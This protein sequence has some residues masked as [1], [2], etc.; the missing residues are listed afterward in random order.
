M[1]ADLSG[2]DLP[3]VERLEGGRR[4]RSTNEF[5][6]FG[7]DEELIAGEC[8]SGG[9]ERLLL[10]ADFAGL[11]FDAT[12][13]GGRIEA[14]IGS[15]V[16]SVE[17]TIEVDAGCVVIGKNVVARPDFLGAAWRDFQEDSAETIA[18]GKKYL[19][20]HNKWNGGSDGGANGWAKWI[21]KEDFFTCRIEGDKVG[22]G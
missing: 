11:E 2:K 6:F 8:E 13:A 21:L 9:T 22:E 5:A 15:A 19:I 18:G 1:S 10:P 16:N 7:Q 4:G 12:K 3:A 14:G 17:E 20:V